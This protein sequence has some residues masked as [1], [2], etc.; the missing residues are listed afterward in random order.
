MHFAFKLAAMTCYLLMNFFVRNLILT[1]IFV[2][3]LV[4]MDFWTVKNVTGRKL[5]GLRWWSHIKEDGTEEWKFESESR[6]INKADHR[7]FWITNYASPVAWVI[8]SFLNILTF[9]I[10]NAM[11]CVFSAGLSIVNVMAYRQC[12]ANHD[13]NVKGFLMDQAQKNLTPQ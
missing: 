11:I 1:Y 13:A 6:E 2:L 7:V 3:T 12:E 9:S 4:I 8:L 5:V 10:S